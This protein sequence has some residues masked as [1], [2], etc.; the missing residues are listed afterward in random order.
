MAAESLSGTAGNDRLFGAGGDV[1]SGG[2][3]DDTYQVNS[4]GDTAAE[5]A[6]Q[7]TDTVITWLASYT[8]PD[9]VENLVFTGNSWSQGTGNA[10][11]NI[12]IGNEAPNTLN[13]KAGDDVL[14]GGAG[15]DTIVVARREGHDV[16]T[17]F[18]GAGSAG[19]DVLALQGFGN[20]VTLTHEGD[21]WSI[22]AADGGVTEITI[23][24]VTNLSA[25]DY[26]FG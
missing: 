17:D 26:V 2:Q 1:L 4:F 25:S 20:G 22:H 6:G 21:V 10:M 15:N 13:G 12:I 14:T 16:I 7:G 19:G 5:K 9:N 8:L 23:D 3:G 18:Q 24:N 11:A